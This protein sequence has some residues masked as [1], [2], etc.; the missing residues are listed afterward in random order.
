VKLTWRDRIKASFVAGRQFYL[1]GFQRNPLHYKFPKLLRHVVGTI[2][3]M[4]V[5][6]ARALVR[7][8]RQQYPYIQNYLHDHTL[9][10]LREL[11]GLYEQY[12]GRRHN[13][14]SQRVD[15]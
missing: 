11:G 2:L 15:A 14:I 9:L 12:R 5:D 1:S 10:Y 7:R 13:N 4:G 6:I 3:R 8:D